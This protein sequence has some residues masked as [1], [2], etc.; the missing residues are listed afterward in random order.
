MN[1]RPSSDFPDPPP[2]ADDGSGDGRLAEE[3]REAHQEGSPSFPRRAFVWILVASV[4]LAPIW[5]SPLLV[6]TD[7]PSHVYNAFVAHDV[8]SGGELARYFDV[9]PPLRPQLLSD[10]LLR[11]LGPLVGWPLAERILVSLGCLLCGIA[12]ARWSRSED[13]GS[14]AFLA[15]IPLGWFTWMGFYDFLFSLAFFAL[16]ATGLKEKR[17]LLVQLSLAG[18]LAT[19]LFT[20]TIG[21]LLLWWC[22]PRDR[23]HRPLIVA[24]AWSVLLL[25]LV[26]SSGS[27]SGGFRWESPPDLRSLL[28]TDVILSHDP[29]VL[30]VGLLLFGMVAW[31]AASHGKALLTPGSLAA[32]GLLLLLGSLLAPEWIGRGGYVPQRL[33]GLGLV[34]LLPTGFQVVRHRTGAVAW[35]ALGALSLAIM[36]AQAARIV[37]S[38]R[39]VEADLESVREALQAAGAGPG[40]QLATA[41]GDP[42]RHLYR[43]Y[44]Y[45]HLPERLA[46]PWRAVVLDDYEASEPV[47]PVRWR[48]GT[49]GVKTAIDE[50]VVSV[51]GS[52]TGDLYLIH[53]ALDSVVAPSPA[54]RVVRG[55]PFTVSVLPG[56]EGRRA[57]RPR[58][59]R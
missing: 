26:A 43:I 27:A 47:F 18:L 21:C 13:L 16:L 12:L 5:L 49:S 50:G 36:T 9:A 58:G 4:M 29:L 40:V 15:W 32:F 23:G 34:L 54:E 22:S 24:T 33:R 20:A 8:R 56:R 53:E 52:W 10:S 55:A 59:G 38:S 37:E 48:E 19:H 57:T 1:R 11:A 28:F 7:G 45:R 35:T 31:G 41:I 30:I 42:F 51:E 17:A 6:T 39:T 3:V 46:I 44:G 2:K 25:A 14:L